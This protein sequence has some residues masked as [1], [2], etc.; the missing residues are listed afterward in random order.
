LGH[1]SVFY[2]HFLIAVELCILL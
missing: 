2:F 1:Q